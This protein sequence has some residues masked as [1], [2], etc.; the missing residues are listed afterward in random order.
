LGRKL[1][2]DELVEMV[3]GYSAII[4]GTE[5]LTAKVM[6]SAGSL[7][8]ISRVGIGLD[9]VDLAAAHKRGIQ[10]C[11][12]PDAPAPAVAELTLGLMLS[13]VRSIHLSNKMMHEGQWKRYFGYRL[14]E[15]TIGIMGVG[16]IGSKVL[17]LLESFGVKKVLLNDIDTEIEVDF[18]LDIEWVDKKTLY[19]CSDILT[20]H[21]PLTE[22][23]YN[24][25]TRNELLCMKEG[26]F[27][28]N[29]ARGGIIN[30]ADLFEILISGHLS[31]AAIDVFEKEPY[32]GR[33]NEVDNC[34]LTSH[35]GSMSQDC[36]VRMEV[37]ATQEVVNW[38]CGGA[39]GNLVL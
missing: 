26:A 12:T 23:T 17:T 16:R 27:I 15:M 6:D 5:S 18:S 8:L 4:A 31:G 25:I 37:E 11:Y 7:K 20:L 24:L 2:E 1:T 29:T 35:M 22:Q 21:V 9:S 39:L 28:I 34:I 38:V 10:V 32:N 13:L 30:E 3:K 19:A 33:L 14:S 36:R